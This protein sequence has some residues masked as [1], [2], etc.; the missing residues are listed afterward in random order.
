MTHK[1]SPDPLGS[2]PLANS[3]LAAQQGLFP[4]SAAYA[5][6]AEAMRDI[7]Q[8]NARYM[9]ELMDAQTAL[10]AA[11]LTQGDETDESPTQ[12]CHRPHH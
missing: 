8:V 6:M 11:C 9:Q 5:R 1:P 4:A 2:L 7:A 10:F 12:H 3:F